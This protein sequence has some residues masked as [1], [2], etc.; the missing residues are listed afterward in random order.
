MK[1]LIYLSL[2]ISLHCNAQLFTPY[3]N[4]FIVQPTSVNS[5]FGFPFYSIEEDNA[6][7]LTAA[8][9]QTDIPADHDGDGLSTIDE[10][11]NGNDDPTDDDY[12]GDGIP[13]YLE[14]NI[15]DE[16]EDGVS[17]QEDSENDN[18]N[19]DQDGDGFPN[20]DEL[21]NGGNPNDP[22]IIP[23]IELIFGD[24]NSIINFISP[25]GDGINEFW[26]IPEIDR[27]QN[28][29]V[30]VFFPDGRLVFEASPYRNNWAG[31]YNGNQLP[32][33]SYLYQIDV[34]GDGIVDYENWLFVAR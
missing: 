20:I 9:I 19:N 32:Q 21:Q 29:S 24:D 22:N 1:R 5:T 2:I 27:Y 4:S 6:P 30:K 28:C 23:D 25:N 16:D 12:D 7:T 26:Q 15:A 18:P 31:T 33:G 17:D 13:D 10:D 34:N 11:A 14:S 8:V 3:S